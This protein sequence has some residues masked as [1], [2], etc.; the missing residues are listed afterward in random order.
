MKK[1]ILIASVVLSFLSVMASEVKL[2]TVDMET[3]VL[4]HPQTEPN[5]AN[6]LKL[7]KE[8]EAERDVKRE[9]LRGLYK[10]LEGLAREADNEAL[11]ELERKKKFNEG[12]EVGQSI[13][14]EEKALREL[15][16]SLQQRLRERELFLFNTVMDDIR[17][18][19]QNLVKEKGYDVVL[20]ASAQR[21][22]APIPLVMYVKPEL[23]ITDAVIQAVGGKRVDAPKASVPAP[24]P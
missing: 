11:S 6:L 16:D 12:R 24:K 18:A 17:F 5:K 14:E 13:K 2:V 20:D 10:R 19:I 4:S 22:G 7:Q 8:F 23:D 1:W 9:K 21:S 15:V 3:V